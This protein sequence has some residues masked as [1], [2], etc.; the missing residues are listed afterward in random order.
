LSRPENGILEWQIFV[1]WLFVMAI[2]VYFPPNAE[3]Q[4][5]KEK[6]NPASI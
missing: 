6:S 4:E 2:D 5:K 3:N 1:G